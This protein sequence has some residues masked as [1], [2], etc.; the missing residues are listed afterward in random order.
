MKIQGRCAIVTGAGNGIGQAVGVELAE[1]GA[2]AVALVDRNESVIRVARMINDRMDAPIAEPMIGDTT[3]EAF[4]RKVFDHMLRQARCARVCVPAA[5]INRDQLAVKLDRSTGNAVMYPIDNFRLL[6][7]VN[8]IAPVY[9]AMEMVGHRRG[10]P[11]TTAAGSGSRTRGPRA[12]SSSSGRSRRRGYPARSP[13]ARPRPRLEGPRTLS[14]EAM[15][16]GVRCAVIHPGFTDTQMVR[17]LGEELH[18]DEHPALHP[19]E[20]ADRPRGDRRCHLLHDLQLGRQR[21]ALGRRRL[22]P[23]R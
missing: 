14:K 11:G 5:A 13:T 21:R 22:A 18:P 6:V 8:L 10:A 4:R 20:A 1:R 7:E 12:P 15:Y 19:V 23:P 3:D 16:Y 2:G 9:W 17:A